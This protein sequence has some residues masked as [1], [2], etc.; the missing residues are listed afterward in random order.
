MADGTRS[1][2]A[3]TTT[4]RLADDF[5]RVRLLVEAADKHARQPIDLNYIAVPAEAWEDIVRV[6]R[7]RG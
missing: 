4:E 1:A 5:E 6:V 7:S 2:V 3:A